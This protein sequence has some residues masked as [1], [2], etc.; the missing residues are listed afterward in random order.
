MHFTNDKRASVLTIAT[1]HGATAKMIEKECHEK[2]R[3]LEE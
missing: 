2:T 1:P 3:K